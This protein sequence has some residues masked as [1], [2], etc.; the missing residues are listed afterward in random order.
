MI[1]P[2]ILLFSLLFYDIS[3]KNFMNFMNNHI[4]SGLFVKKRLNFNCIKLIKFGFYC[5]E[6]YIDILFSYNLNKMKQLVIF[7][8]FE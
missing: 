1:R 7:I 6:N 5:I 4:F 8:A 2:N 3:K